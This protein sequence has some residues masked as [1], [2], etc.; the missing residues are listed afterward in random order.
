MK[1]KRKIASGGW[2]FWVPYIGL[3][4]V[5]ILFGILSEGKLFSARNL[6]MLVNQVMP[7]LIICCGAAFYWA[8]GAI[9]LSVAGVLGVACITSALGFNTGSIFLAFLFPN[10]FYTWLVEYID[11]ASLNTEE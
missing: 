5:C 1:M 7:L 8:H 11:A 6:K 2:E 3:V 9:D 10:A 4:V